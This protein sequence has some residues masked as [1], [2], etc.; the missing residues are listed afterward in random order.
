MFLDCNVQSI[1]VQ[2]LPVSRYVTMKRGKKEDDNRLYLVALHVPYFPPPCSILR[3]EHLVYYT[4][5]LERT[6]WDWVQ[7]MGQMIYGVGGGAENKLVAS[8]PGD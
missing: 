5:V 2:R 3:G 1:L 4:A 7:K 6:E 8:F